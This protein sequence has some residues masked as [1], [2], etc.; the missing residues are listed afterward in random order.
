[1]STY[2]DH[3][4]PEGLL[5][6]GTVLIVPGRGET[7]ATYDRLGRRL[8]ADAWRVRVLDAPATDPDGWATA[9]ARLGTRLSEALAGIG[10]DDVAEEARASPARPLVLLGADTGAA[11]LAALLAGPELPAA[12]RPDGVVLAGLPAPGTAAAPA[13]AHDWDAELE[14]RT[15]CPTHRGR[16]TDDA[17]VHRGAL[18]S[19]VPAAL[20]T[21]AYESDP[22]VPALLL[23]GD[24]DPLGDPAALA[25]TTASLSR[26]RLA[27]VRGAHHDVLNDLQHRAVAAEIVTFLET[28]RN[29][30]VPLVA[31]ESSTW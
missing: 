10:A 29:G 26:A 1:M 19:P 25:R 13:T 11:A 15:A 3:P 22:G 27:V 5:V 12:A 23:T 30:L 21:A 14:V 4:T 16:L 24:A 9:P 17:G 20:L 7:R 8:A 6:R 28:L 31:V 18:D 2:T